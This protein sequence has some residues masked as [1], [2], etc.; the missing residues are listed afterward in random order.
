M[1]DSSLLLRPDDSL[2]MKKIFGTLRLP[3]HA[4]H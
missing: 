2:K 1:I 3:I 4:E